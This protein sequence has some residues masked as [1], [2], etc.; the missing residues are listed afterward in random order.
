MRRYGKASMFVLVVCAVAGTILLGWQLV[1]WATTECKIPDPST[2]FCTDSV[3]T[4]DCAYQGTESEC[5]ATISEMTRNKFPL[6]PVTAA[7]GVTTEEEAPCW[8]QKGCLW[9]DDGLYCG[10][11]TTFGRWHNGDKVVVDTTVTCPTE[12]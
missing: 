6:G 9:D 5:A 7:S 8:Q 2:E 10:T 4:D 3:D 11:A 12:E 1:G